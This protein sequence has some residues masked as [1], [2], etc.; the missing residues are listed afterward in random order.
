MNKV[1][2]FSKIESFIE[3][4]PGTLAKTKKPYK[5]DHF[6]LGSHESALRMQGLI[7]VNDDRHFRD[8]LISDGL[9][10]VIL[11][12]FYALKTE[13]GYQ[14]LIYIPEI[15]KIGWLYETELE[16]LEFNT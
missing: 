4:L 9:V 11:S 12:I 1:P 15:E 7:Q 16:F 3:K 8:T 13:Y 14:V 6:L 2:K 5:D 10:C